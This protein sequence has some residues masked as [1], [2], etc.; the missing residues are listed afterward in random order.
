MRNCFNIRASGQFQQSFRRVVTSVALVGLTAI[1]QSGHAASDPQTITV[2]GASVTYVQDKLW[3]SI[4]WITPSFSTPISHE[5][6][7]Y[8]DALNERLKATGYEINVERGGIALAV[9][10]DYAGKV[11]DYK[12]G[13]DHDTVRGDAAA[14][15]GTTVLA[16]IGRAFGVSVPLTVANNAN[17]FV[18][19]DMPNAQ[20][21]ELAGSGPDRFLV[22]ARICSVNGKRCGSSV[23]VST[24][25]S[26]SLNELRKINMQQGLTRAVGLLPE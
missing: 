1:T 4:L 26:V 22:I 16:A 19:R 25:Q 15:V 17:S 2:E 5:Y 9:F 11:S 8:I 24:D 3:S 10:E 21:S 6:P 7:L 12:P 18:V 23:S 20:K 14:I 13:P